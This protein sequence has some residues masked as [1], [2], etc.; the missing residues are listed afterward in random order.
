MPTTQTQ[1][2]FLKITDEDRRRFGRGSAI[3]RILDRIRREYE[4]AEA[5]HPVGKGS[6]FQFTFA[7]DP[8]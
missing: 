5:Q 4:L 2:V 8:H 3:D 7:V 1:T 6:E